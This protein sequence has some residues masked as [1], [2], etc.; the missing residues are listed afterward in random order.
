MWFYNNGGGQGIGIDVPN[1]T[2]PPDA[3]GLTETEI[4]A[5][6]AFMKSLTDIETFQSPAPA[7]PDFESIPELQNR[8][9]MTY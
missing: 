2:L 7:L 1:Q 8:T 4:N 9:A 3:L 5:V 6:I